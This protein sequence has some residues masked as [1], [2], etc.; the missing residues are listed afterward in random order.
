M[1]NS[2][3]DE[4]RRPNND[5]KAGAISSDL[6]FEVFESAIR[7]AARQHGESVA[8]NNRSIHQVEMISKKV[9]LLES[10]VWNKY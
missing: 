10:E 4:L 3:L 2:E 5:T 9:L 6:S 1:T 7:S 8:H